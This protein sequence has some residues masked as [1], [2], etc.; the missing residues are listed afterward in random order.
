MLPIFKQKANSDIMINHALDIVSKATHHLNPDQTPIICA[1]Q[2][3]YASL[4][5]NLFNPSTSYTEE[6]YY[7]WPLTIEMMIDCL[8][9]D[10]LQGIGWVEILA[11]VGVV[12]PG[13]GEA[14]LKSSHVTRARYCYQISAVVLPILLDKAYDTYKC[15]NVQPESFDEWKEGQ[16]LESISFNYWYTCLKL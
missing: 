8:I 4:K 13:R 2:P 5:Q 1:D 16:M 10:W 9:G 15:S 3:F 6:T 12:T 7:I 14:I 11:K